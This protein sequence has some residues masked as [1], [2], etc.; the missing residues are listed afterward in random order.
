MESSGDSNVS[1]MSIST[2]ALG[3]AACGSGGGGG[4]NKGGGGS[5]LAGP[6]ASIWVGLS[7]VLGLSLCLSLGPLSCAYFL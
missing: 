5:G 3:G 6:V 1:V 7:C 4:E 2:G